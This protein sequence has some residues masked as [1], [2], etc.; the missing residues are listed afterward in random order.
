[1][2]LKKEV[3]HIAKLARLNLSPSEVKSFQK[4]LSSILDYVNLLKKVDVSM[5]EPTSHPRLIKNVVREDEVKKQLPKIIIELAKLAPAIKHN[6]I[7][8]K[9]IF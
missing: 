8:V 1:M 9:S 2:I 6:F 4:E 5:V 3:N 7:K